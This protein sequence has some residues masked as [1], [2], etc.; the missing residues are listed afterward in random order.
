MRTTVTIDEELVRKLMEM[1]GTQTKTQAV[2][3]AIKEEL[4]R[5]K[6]RQLAD[7]LGNIEIDESAHSDVDKKDQERANWLG[8]V[9]KKE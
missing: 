6:L 2:I 3:R 8:D 4:R 9:G 7:L 5:N 1:Y